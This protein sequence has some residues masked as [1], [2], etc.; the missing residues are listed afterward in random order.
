MYQLFVLGELMSGPAHGYSIQERL[1]HAVGPMRRISSGTLYPLL[2]R[3]SDHGLIRLVPGVEQEDNRPRK[4]Y[5][6]TE[7]GR[8]RFYEQM[9]APL[10]YGLDTE[11]M[12]HFK[13][14]HSSHLS[15]AEQL[16]CLEQYRDFVQHKLEH[17][18]N[19]QA[20]V[21]LKQIDPVKLSHILRVLD[22]KHSLAQAEAAWLEAEI[23]RTAETGRHHKP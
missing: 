19:Q 23:K 6:L 1:K 17:V 21:R 18:A 3:L 10:E 11:L 9:R 12:F 20:A 8:Q 2:T 16:H 22:H 4:Q 5:E 15:L 14:V 7:Q 13:L